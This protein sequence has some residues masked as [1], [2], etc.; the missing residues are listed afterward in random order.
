[1]KNYLPTL[2]F[3]FQFS[4]FDFFL[5][6]LHK[7]EISFSRIKLVLLLFLVSTSLWAQPPHTFNLDGSLY[8]PAGITQMTVQAWGG[9]GAGGGASGAAPLTLNGRGGAGGGGGAYAMSIITVVPGTTLNVVVAKQVA[10]AVTGVGATGG[11]STITGFENVIKAV[12]GEGG[13]ANNS[14]TTPAGGAGGKASASSGTTTADGGNGGPGV[15]AILSIL[16]SGSGGSGALPSGG[17]GGSGVAIALIG[18]A[19][20]NAGAPPGGGGSG[21]VQ[22][23]GGA[24]Q[25]GGA[26]AAG[27]VS[28]NYTCPTYNISG[29]TATNVCTTTGSS[30]VT[31]T[32]SAASLPVGVYTVTYNL[33]NPAVVGLT[34]QM[35]VN[36]A[37]TGS[38]FADALTAAATR[39]ITITNLTSGV[40]VSNI[41]SNNTANITISAPTVGGGVS[42]G[43]TICSGLT[44]A[45]LLL[46]GHTGSVLKWQYA[47]S[48]FT[49]WVDI[50]NTTV[51][52]TSGALTQTTQFRAVVQS[53]VC[54]LDFSTPTTVTVNPLPQGSLSANGPFCATGS[55]QLTFTGT[56]GTGPYVVVYK[57]NG[58]ADRT[59]TNVTSGVAFIPFTSSVNTSTIYTLVS[60]ADAN[61]CTRNNGF[62]GNSATVTVI[63]K[64]SAPQLGQ[65]VQPTCVNPTGSVVLNGLIA[66]ANWTITQSGTFSKTYSGSGTNFTVPNLAPGNYTFTIHEDSSCLSSATASVDINAPITN[67]WNGTS[68]SKGRAPIVTDIIEFAGNYETTGNLTG[69]SCVVNSGVNVVVNSD[70][71]LTIVNSVTNNGGTLT[72]ENNAG[73][74]QTSDAINTGNIIYKRNTTPVRRYDFTYWSSPVTRTPPFTLK[75]LSPDTLID[76]Y[77]SYDPSTGWVYNNGGT[78][79]M[80]PGY[81]YMIRAPQI[82]DINIPAIYH[83]QFTGVPNNGPI[84][85]PLSAPEKFHLIGNPYPSAIYAD[86]FIVDNAA[87][88]YGTLLFWTHNS[89]PSGA[90]GDGKYRYD[91]D[92]YAIYNLTGDISIGDLDGTGATTPGNQNPPLG[93]IAA[94]QSFFVKSKTT[95]NAVFTNS[96]RVPGNNSQFFKMTNASKENLDRHRLWLNFTNTQGAFKQILIGY[97]E[98]ATNLW[99]NL[100]DAL[101]LDANK[102]VD[103][104]SINELNKLVIQGRAV[105]FLE[106][107]VI[108]LGY[109]SIIAGEFTISIDHADGDLS[110]HAI[111]LEDKKTNTI[112]NLQT[113]NY[114]FTTTTGTFDNRFVLR[115]TDKSLKRSDFKDADKAIFVFVKDKIINVTSTKENIS[116][117]AIFDLTGKLLYSKNKI[118]ADQWQIPNLKVENQVLVVKTTLEN[119]HTTSDKIVF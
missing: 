2:L 40:C 112:H 31:L 11:T 76:K 69:C 24:G 38:F 117:V 10:G 47:V 62:T 70:H 82:F 56:A 94:G 83:A 20:G 42:G 16:V 13:N 88:L 35:T 22:S 104:Y 53:G 43:T 77:F 6:T 95:L 96:M 119:K 36:T 14:G 29:I 85:V 75:D 32:S 98:G 58:G 107:D 49:S 60:V 39:T 111:F 51:N 55:P 86:Q 78:Q 25:L 52:Y 1:M 45:A 105:P 106:T 81:G 63:S 66:T 114:N 7:K 61:I 90:V 41:S 65:I 108:P 4:I 73:L 93:Y 9:G 100:Y 87:N 5:I 54:G 89:L 34:K 118:N 37:G 17:S 57:E 79:A 109:R 110:T 12:G 74:L 28:I 80:I 46:T 18:N 113:S 3:L 8:V 103:F 48:P 116:E 115:F 33:S 101:T 27:Q 26:G 68:W 15:T 84:T 21:A 71:T 44:S 59:A 97:V 67:I 23:P 72:F 64:P 99:D 30:T 102:Y 50:P 19:P 92:D 91:S